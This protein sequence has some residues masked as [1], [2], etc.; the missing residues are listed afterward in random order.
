MKIIGIYKIINRVNNKYYV[1]SSINITEG[2]GRLARHKTDLKYNRHDNEHLQ[3]AWNSYGCDNFEFV[4][5]EKLDNITKK[6][7][8]LV[9]QKYL[10]IAKTELDKCYNMSFD[11]FGTRYV[12]S[13]VVEK[14]RNSQKRRVFSEESK[15][16][17]SEARKGWV[18]SPETLEK[19]KIAKRGKNHPLFG[20]THSE[21][22]KTKMSLSKTGSN[23]NRYDSTV[24]KFINKITNELFEGTQFELSKKYNLNNKNVNLMVNSKKYRKSVGGWSLQT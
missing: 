7:L 6:E 23:N 16:R 1:G 20:K 12:R 21:K 18:Y 14:R 17:M 19:M 10:D 4:I 8:L 13:E 22:T 9:E 24:R 3:R 11:A 15:K 5:V 2:K